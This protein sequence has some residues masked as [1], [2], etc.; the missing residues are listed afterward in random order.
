M[1]PA[2]AVLSAA[3]FMSLAVPACAQVRGGGGARRPAYGSN[4]W[5][6]SGGATLL[7]LGPVPDGVSG[8]Q[9]DF[10]G[11]PRWTVRGTIEKTIQPT[12]TFGIGVNH[13]TVDLRYQPLPGAPPVTP[14]PE[15]GE[16]LARCRTAGCA[17]QLDFG[18]VQAVLRGGGADEGLYQI[19]EVTG[20]VNAF[21]NVRS[22]TDDTPL[23]AGTILDLTA[24]LGYGLGFA[25]SRDLHLAFVQDWGIAWRTRDGLPDGTGRTYRTRNSRVTLRYGLGTFRRR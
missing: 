3:L 15:A 24:G 7:G 5:W 8:S 12:T 13:G 21:R 22:R 14:D 20:G 18:G 16:E 10:S 6:V 2:L 4:A 23:P 9:W 17:A 11:D 1:R 19:V 25:L